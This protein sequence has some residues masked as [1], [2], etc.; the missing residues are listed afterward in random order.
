[1]LKLAAVAGRELDLDIFT[2]LQS[3]SDGYNGDDLDIWLLAGQEAGVLAVQENRW[4]FAHDKLRQA[5]LAD[6]SEAER[7]AAHQAVAEAIEQTY[8]DA[9]VQASLLTRHWEAANHA[10]KAQRYAFVAGQYAVEQYA[11]EEAVS[12]FGRALALTSEGDLK[13]QYDCL[14][15]REKVFNLLGKRESQHQD[16]TQLAALADKMDEPGLQA[17]IALRQ[18]AY[19][20]VVGDLAEANVVAQR[21]VELAEAAGDHLQSAAGQLTLG[22]ILRSLGEH[23]EARMYLKQCLATYRELDNRRGEGAALIALGHTLREL[24]EHDESRICL[25][26]GLTIGQQLGNRRLETRALNNLGILLESE[27]MSFQAQSFFTQ[28]L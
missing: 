10:E 21:A 7:V 23:A 9:P 26:Q 17:A 18:A 25:E 11:N 12:F 6:L 19:F 14:L 15:A 13:T 8:G 22:S 27:G 3:R 2:H 5:V 20:S 28:G 4:R 1:M 24:G 16:V